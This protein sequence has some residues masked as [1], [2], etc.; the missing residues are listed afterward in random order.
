VFIPPITFAQVI[1]VYDG[2]T[3]TIATELEIYRSDTN[4]KNQKKEKKEKKEKNDIYR[5]SVRLKDIDSPEI[6]G[7]STTEKKLAI[8]ARNALHAKIFGKVVELKNLSYEKYGRL[9]ADVYC[10]GVHINQWMLEQKF[11]VLY[12]GKTKTRPLEWD[13]DNAN[14]KLSIDTSKIDTDTSKFDVQIFRLKEQFHEIHYK[15]EIYYTE[16]LN[17]GVILQFK[18]QQSFIFGNMVNGKAF[19]H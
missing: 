6:H 14:T 17:N 13:D 2:D 18:N 19:F 4:E 15:G 11:A 5:F 7:K 10:D 1:K 16:N 3:I 9:L 12:N 8:D